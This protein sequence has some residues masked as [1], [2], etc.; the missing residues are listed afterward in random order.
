VWSEHS[1]SAVTLPNADDVVDAVKAEWPS[2]EADAL[3][4]A[5]I[6][7]LQNGL[8]EPTLDG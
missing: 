7:C 2:V 6:P 8:P 1:T 4:T 3:P 5:G